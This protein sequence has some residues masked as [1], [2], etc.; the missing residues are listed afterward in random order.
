MEKLSTLALLFIAYLLVNSC[1]SNSSTKEVS[2][3]VRGNCGM[4]EERI[5]STASGIK[6]I[7]KADWDVKTKAIMVTY[8]TLQVNEGQIQ[9]GIANVGHETKLYASPQEV[10]DALPECCKKGSSM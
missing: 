9:Q 7:I 3:Y 2:F 6:G 5:E 1:N 8:D 10:H 4:C